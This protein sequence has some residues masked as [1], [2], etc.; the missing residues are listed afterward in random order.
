[1]TMRPFT[2]NRGGLNHL[3]DAQ[4]GRAFPVVHKVYQH[5]DAIEYVA[6]VYEAGR[7]RDIVIRTNHTKEWIEWQYKGEAQWTVLFK[8]SDLLGAD[9]A[10]VVAAE[11][12]IANQL[13]LL[14]IQIK[15]VGNDTLT[16]RDK[17]Q[18]AQL[19]AEVAQN[20][21]QLSQQVAETS[22]SNAVATLASVE[23][24]KTAAVDAA[25]EAASSKEIVL[26]AVTTNASENAALKLEMQGLVA[27]AAESKDAAEAHKVSA[28]ASAS[29]AETHKVSAETAANSANLANADVL[30]KAQD[31][32][33]KHSEVL[34]NAT[35]VTDTA[36]QVSL[37]KNLVVANAA[38]AALDAVAAGTSAKAAAI[39][40]GESRVNAETAGTAA[41]AASVDKAAVEAIR[42][43][44]LAT[45]TSVTNLYIEV[46]S[47]KTAVDVA[48][49]ATQAVKT[50]T[51]QL[52]AAAQ[53]SAEAANA[54]AGISTQASNTAVAASEAALQFR[55]ETQDI[56]DS[57]VTA[58]TEQVGLATAQAVR[59]EDAADSI[60]AA[61]SKLDGIAEGA[62]DNQT[63]AFLLNR[64]NHTG[65]QAISTVTGL[66]DAIDSKQETL[67]S[68]TNIKTINGGSILGAGNLV[69]SGGGGSSGPTLQGDTAPL[70]TQTKTYTIT[71]Y[72]SFSSYAVAVS[73]GAVSISGDTITFVAPATAGGV[74]LT[75]TV[76]GHPT[77]F[78]VAVQAAPSYIPTPTPTP[79]NFGD[80][81]EGG[82][83][84]GMVWG[85]I[86]Q[87]S[88]SMAIATGSKTFV[89]PDMTNA[90]IVYV[91]Q[92]VEVRSRANPANKFLGTVT[93]A[94]GTN[95]T[96]NVTSV[97]GSGTFSDWSVMARHR[98][99]VAPR[100][101][102]E[103][104]GIALKNTYTPLPTA[105]QTLTEG[106]AATQAMRDADTSTVYPA[107]HWARNL[108]IGGRTDWYI[109]A[110]DELELCWRNLKPATTDNYVVINRPPAASSFSYA[111]NGSYGSY[112]DT[113][114]THG[115]N[116]NSSPTGAA[117]TASVPGQTAATAFRTGGAEAYEFGS[118]YYWSSSD[119]SAPYAWFQC[120]HS[121]GPGSQDNGAKAIAYRV[122]AVRRSII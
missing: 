59:A 113:A 95:L 104:A 52:S 68:G 34:A 7:A 14:K 56:R 22:A 105:C 38:Q 37:D 99:I 115:T 92:M 75:L 111:T 33:T 25:T 101:S 13:E 73:A 118:T 84:A 23:V 70:G 87:S 15:V 27:T 71:N 89:V 66:Q 54:S 106:F 11:Q 24:A 39:S 28:E 98:I 64:A 53:V 16:A 41:T 79:A 90:P 1:M 93:G 49:S 65:S 3:V 88:T 116:N 100:A 9:I 78:A 120:W 117:Y 6:Q 82:F 121:A 5:L 10:D 62:T 40:A 81:L 86:A 48:A 35:T 31:V 58:A 108:N 42:Q 57:A 72:S 12:A 74:T 69:I 91:G 45:E 67:V 107:A 114:N 50:D 55:N 2:D 77:E 26:G 20:A 96:I 85:Q 17:A 43:N 102:G 8:F 112:G 110:R 32:A 80:P 94:L 4:I 63:D 21:A 30:A 44:V 36:T 18:T 61:K 109:P 46:S 83:Y 51:E 103:H 47:L 122:R 19:A 119:Y 60:A 97:E 76:D 29:S